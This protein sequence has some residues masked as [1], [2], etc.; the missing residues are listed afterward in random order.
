MTELW[1]DGI[2]DSVLR[3]R[4]AEAGDLTPTEAAYLIDH[5]DQTDARWGLALI[6]GGDP[7]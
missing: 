7:W 5:R 3:E 4:L 2:P 1:V 6:L